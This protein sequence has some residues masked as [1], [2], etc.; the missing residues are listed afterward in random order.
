M[1]LKPVDNLRGFAYQRPPFVAF[2]ICLL[3]FA[4]ALISLGLY[5]Q[6]HKVQNYETEDWNNFFKSFSDQRFCIPLNDSNIS[7]PPSSPPLYSAGAP[8]TQDPGTDEFDISD[9]VGTKNVSVSVN[10]DILFP[11][12]DVVAYGNI[13]LTFDLQQAIP[14][15]KCKD[16]SCT[17]WKEE[18]SIINLHLMYTSYFLF[19][20]LI[21][22]VFYALIKGPPFKQRVLHENGSHRKP[23]TLA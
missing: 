7:Q 22:S 10:L 4:I 21:T 1:A 17:A 9:I 3:L 12:E 5:M 15:V 20:M 16:Q 18:K 8:T 6:N 11:G 13:A 2:L 14:D 23:M 19:I